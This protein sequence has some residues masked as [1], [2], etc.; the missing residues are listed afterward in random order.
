MH[1]ISVILRGGL[2]SVKDTAWRALISRCSRAWEE[3]KRNSGVKVLYRIQL[4]RIK[5][6]AGA[7]NTVVLLL[8]LVLFFK[9]YF[10]IFISYWS[11]YIIGLD[12]DVCFLVAV[13][14]S[15]MTRSS[16]L[17]IGKNWTHYEQRAKYA[18]LRFEYRATCDD[19]YYGKGCET[20]CRPRDDG[21]GHYTCS[22]SG[23]HVCHDGWDGEY[24]AKRKS[25]NNFHQTNLQHNLGYVMLCQITSCHITSN[26]KQNKIFAD[27][28]LTWVNNWKALRYAAVENKKKVATTTRR[29]RRNNIVKKFTASKDVLG[30]HAVLLL[31]TTLVF[32]RFRGI[33]AG[34]D[35]QPTQI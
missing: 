16:S 6:T 2:T 7:E 30:A 11:P 1:T 19:N 14:I 27:W 32:P 5:P 9:K 28:I 8:F 17:T 34:W 15:R 10:H 35:Q 12:L 3:I 4:P 29:R 22:P 31:A 20:F 23:D 25:F 13:L 18:T 21:F 24:C 33:P 26:T